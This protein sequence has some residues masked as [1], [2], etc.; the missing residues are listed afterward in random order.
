ME[1]EARGQ[2]P[3]PNTG[4]LGLL[5]GVVEKPLGVHLHI[6][7]TRPWPAPVKP[8]PC[9]ATSLPSAAQRKPPGSTAS[10]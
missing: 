3:L 6:P 10:R 9:Q 8:H 2:E 1:T 4:Q 7:A 5:G